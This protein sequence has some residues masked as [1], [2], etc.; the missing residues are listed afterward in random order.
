M[1]QPE[2]YGAIPMDLHI[3]Q[4]GYHP[5]YRKGHDDAPGPPIVQTRKEKV[6][7]G[8]VRWCR[9]DLNI[10]GGLA[11]IFMCFGTWL[12]KKMVLIYCGGVFEKQ[13]GKQKYGRMS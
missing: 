4:Q 1:M 8:K 10:V 5:Y 2:G 11:I 12:K 3:S 13:V 6:D 9:V 7:L